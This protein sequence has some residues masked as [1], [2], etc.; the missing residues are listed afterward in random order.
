MEVVDV[1]VASLRKRGYQSLVEWLAAD[2]RNVYV[3]RANGWVD[4]AKRSQWANPYSVKSHGLQKSL[5]MYTQ[6]IEGL[7]LSE[8]KGCRLGCWCVNSDANEL[9]QMTEKDCECHAQILAV[10]ARQ[11]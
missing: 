11:Q 9:E 3:G 2:K 10:R 5:E 6:H 1:H 4:G 8:L 7:N